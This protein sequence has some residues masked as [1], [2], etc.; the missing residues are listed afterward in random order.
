MTGFNALNGVPVTGDRFTVH[1]ILRE[2]WKFDG[3]VVSDYTAIP[4]MIQHGYAADDADAAKKALLA[5][6]DMEMVSTTYF[7]TLKAQI[8]SGS[9][10]M[11]HVDNA[12]RDILRLKF[13]LGLFDQ[14]AASF[15]P[16]RIRLRLA[17]WMSPAPGSGERGHAEERS[18]YTSP[19]EKSRQSRRDRTRRTALS[20]RWGRGPWTAAG[21]C[22]DSSRCLARETRRQQSLIR[23]GL[24]KQPRLSTAGFDEAIAAARAADVVLLFLGEDRFSPARRIPVRFSIC[25]APRRSW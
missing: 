8:R 9:L 17:R 2:E 3:M 5:G 1:H 18:R 21:R 15:S 12:V 23:A 25:P 24:E 7:D 6:V 20:T 4:E 16:D 13:R 22:A 10:D 11:Q 19:G 14:D